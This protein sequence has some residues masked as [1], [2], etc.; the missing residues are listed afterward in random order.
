M[1]KRNM[2]E[3]VPE[4]P[5]AT[6]PTA[7]PASI[8]WGEWIVNPSNI[9]SLPVTRQA[10][11]A[12][13]GAKVE[14]TMKSL[15]VRSLILTVGVLLLALT[16]SGEALAQLSIYPPLGCAEPSGGVCVTG[17]CDE[18]VGDDCDWSNGTQW[19]ELSVSVE[20][21]LYCGDDYCPEEDCDNPETLSASGRVT[22]T[23]TFG[24]PDTW[25]EKVSVCEAIALCSNPSIACVRCTN[26]TLTN[27][28]PT[29]ALPALECEVSW[30]G[31]WQY[32]IWTVH[33]DLTECEDG[34]DD[35]DDN[36]CNVN[37]DCNACDLNGYGHAASCC[38]TIPS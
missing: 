37:S 23:K 7:L 24:S 30:A 18:C 13:F 4:R 36:A 5:T 33:L 26:R 15:I 8:C 3:E 10:D 9:A 19:G 1:K 34:C 21:G 17:G 6:C 31:E 14:E 35:T 22:M 28:S 25:S 2:K 12:V 20:D 11:C 38:V 32:H 16:P 27:A 29:Y